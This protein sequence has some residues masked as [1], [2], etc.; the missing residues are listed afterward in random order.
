MARPLRASLRCAAF[1]P[2]SASEQHGTAKH[3][4][5]GALKACLVALRGQ[6]IGQHAGPVSGDPRAA[7]IKQHKKTAP[8]GPRGVYLVGVVLGVAALQS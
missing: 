5:R 1:M 6:P 3:T 4:P 7:A 2:D 8:M